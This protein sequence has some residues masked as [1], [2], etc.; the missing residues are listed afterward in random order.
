MYRNLEGAEKT[1]WGASRGKQRPHVLQFPG[2][3]HFLE[4]SFEL[5]ATG[6]EQRSFENMVLSREGESRFFGVN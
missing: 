3:D 1:P 6:V 5:A 2:H 4:V